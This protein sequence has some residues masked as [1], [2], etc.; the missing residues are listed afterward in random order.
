VGQRG[1]TMARTTPDQ[2][3]DLPASD[4]G[5]SG[6]DYGVPVSK[7]DLKRGFLDV[8]P[9]TDPTRD[10]TEDTWLDAPQGGVAGRPRGWA[11]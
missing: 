5:I 11:R 1:L 4:A 3:P 9:N 2:L 10:G 6:G 8:A 7:A